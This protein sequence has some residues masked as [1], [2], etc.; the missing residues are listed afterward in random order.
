MLNLLRREVQARAASLLVLD[1]L[2]AIEETAA[3]GREFKKFIHEL[4]AQAAIA[5]C[6]MLL[7]TNHQPGAA[8][9][10]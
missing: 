2:S 10:A 3:S 9:Q 1:G 4:Q 8:G 6:M 5:D 7:L